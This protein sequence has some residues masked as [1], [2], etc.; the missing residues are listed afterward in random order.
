MANIYLKLH[1]GKE[2]KATTSDN[3]EAKGDVMAEGY[4]GHIN[5]LSFSHGI[6]FGTDDE[7]DEGEAKEKGR[8]PP[9]AELG[10]SK[11]GPFE[12]SKHV[13]RSSPKLSFMCS[14]G[15]YFDG[16]TLSLVRAAGGE[17][18]ATAK[19][20]KQERYMMYKLKRCQIKS[21]DVE[22]SADGI[23]TEKVKF[24]YEEIRWTYQEMGR[25]T[26]GDRKE[27]AWSTGEHIGRD[28][29]S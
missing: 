25:G 8:K 7:G 11:H 28:D 10:T 3:D 21:V 15:D 13:D 5:V 29:E 14:N 22:G 9:V 17:G 27:T 16:L 18:G 2:K 24:I 4:E 12:I 23:P 20:G 6:N 26:K 1:F 19:A